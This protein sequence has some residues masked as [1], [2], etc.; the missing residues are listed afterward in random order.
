MEMYRLQGLVPV[1]GKITPADP[2]AVTPIPH[3]LI[4]VVDLI[5]NLRLVL[6][7]FSTVLRFLIQNSQA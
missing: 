4:D 1:P 2:N 6:C 5:R 7:W 3:V